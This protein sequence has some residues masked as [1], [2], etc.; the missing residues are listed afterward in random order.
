MADACY[1][2]PDRSHFEITKIKPLNQITMIKSS[3]ATV[4]FLKI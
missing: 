1:M 4:N 3:F 2:Y